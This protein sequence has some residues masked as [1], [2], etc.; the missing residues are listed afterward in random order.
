MYNGNDDLLTVDE[1]C[2]ILSVG[3]NVAYDLLASGKIRSF[4]INRTWSILRK[5]LFE[6][7]AK[8]CLIKHS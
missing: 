3:K 6:Y 1:L 5:C 4:K 7:V 8:E 2:E